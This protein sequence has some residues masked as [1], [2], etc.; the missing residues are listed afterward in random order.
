MR[1]VFQAGLLGR[2]VLPEDPAVN[3][4]GLVTNAVIGALKNDCSDSL[5]ASLGWAPATV[6][7][8]LAP[9]PYHSQTDPGAGWVTDSCVLPDLFGMSTV[10]VQTLVE[11]LL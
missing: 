5:G 10:S 6:I 3:L 11:P 2:M 9:F 4:A 7:C 8:W 1:R